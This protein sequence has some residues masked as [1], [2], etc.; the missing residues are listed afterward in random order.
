M[1]KAARQICNLP[2]MGSILIT[3]T[4]A[5]EA[6]MVERRSVKPMVVGSTPSRSANNIGVSSNGLR[7]LA[8]DQ[9]SEGSSPSTPTK[10]MVNKYIVEMLTILKITRVSE[11]SF[12]VLQ[13]KGGGLKSRSI[14]KR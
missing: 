13:D 6:Q 12:L 5:A 14:S 4:N 11:S 10:A 7:H 3:S 2:A 1:S 8:T 9:K